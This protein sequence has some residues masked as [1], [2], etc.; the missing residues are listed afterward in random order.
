MD[1]PHIE[2]IAKAIMYEGYVLY[3]YR[4]SSLKNRLRWTLGV[5]APRSP[6][7]AKDVREN[8]LMQTECLVAGNLNTS[9][10]VEVRF[11]QVVA[12]KVGELCG[13]PHKA[14]DTLDDDPTVRVVDSLQ[15]GDQTYYTW[16]DAI[17]RRV[18]AHVKLADVLHQPRQQFFTFPSSRELTP[19]HDATGNPL[20]VVIHER[21]RLEGEVT[22]MTRRC[23]DELFR[24]T[25][26]IDNLSPAPL[27]QGMANDWDE[28]V[29]RSLVSTH[30]ILR[31]CDGA[32]VSLL[33]PPEAFAAA[34]AECWNV[35]TWPVLVGEPGSRDCL[36][37]SPIILYDYPRIA[38]ESPG[39][40]FD[41]TEIDEL[42]ALRVHTLTEAEKREAAAADP[43]ARALLART[44]S[45]TADQLFNLHG[46]V[47]PLASCGIKPGDRVRLR[48]RG[49]AD[50][51]DLLLDGK[52]ARVVS[53]ERTVD[54]DDYIAVTVDD[55]PGQDFG[56]AKMPGH[57]FFFHPEEVEPLANDQGRRP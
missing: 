5:I 57:R 13:Q 10:D 6:C 12:R 44:D 33:D 11:L 8:V 43:H 4:P 50:A 45:L 48:P 30:T 35:A 47:S 51:F 18:A 25:I 37:S 40:L 21:R 22:T 3:P 32:F 15:V 24:M 42:L 7:A 39:D 20:G 49:G 55:D 36:L 19:L 29:L 38:P 16:Q 9:L 34:A 54:G 46:G 1:L 27:D 41:A 31:A 53:L 17:E 52:T 23:A 2:K 56:A 14:G 26:R 28:V